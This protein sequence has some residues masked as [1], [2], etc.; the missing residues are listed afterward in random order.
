[1]FNIVE[2]YILAENSDQVSKLD[3]EFGSKIITNLNL[4]Y[5]RQRDIK[6]V[7]DTA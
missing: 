1:M 2:I 6:T 5:V 3:V 4:F 7:I